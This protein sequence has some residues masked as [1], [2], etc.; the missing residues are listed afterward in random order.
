M[1]VWTEVQIDIDGEDIKVQPDFSLI[2][3]NITINTNTSVIVRQVGAVSGDGLNDEDRDTLY[4]I[5]GRTIEIQSLLQTS[6]TP[7][8]DDIQAKI[9]DLWRIHGLDKDNPMAVSKEGRTVADIEQVFQDVDDTVIV[10]R[11]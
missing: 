1:S 7:T 11:E 5:E 2:T 6:V 3:S 4:N 10:L 8:L 9:L